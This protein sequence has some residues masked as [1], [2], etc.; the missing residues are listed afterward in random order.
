MFFRLSLAIYLLFLTSCTI[1]P[2]TDSPESVDVSFNLKETVDIAPLIGVSE[3]CFDGQLEQKRLMYSWVPGNRV[4]WIDSTSDVEENNT[5]IYEWLSSGKRFESQMPSEVLRQI[6]LVPEMSV[7]NPILES[8]SA[9]AIIE[10]IDNA[11]DTVFVDIFLFGGTFGTE[12]ARRLA[13]AAKRGVEVVVLHDTETVFAVGS[14]IEPLWEAV[15]EYGRDNDNFVALRSQVNDGP[16]AIPFGMQSVLVP[17]FDPDGTR[18]V[19]FA[20]RSDHSKLLIVD[21]FSEHPSMLVGSKNLVDAAASYFHDEAVLVEGP[22]AALAQLLFT[23]DLQLALELALDESSI[24]ENDELLLDAW[25][26]ESVERNAAKQ[27]S[28]PVA[29]DISVRLFEA[30]ADDS[31]RN[32]E[33]TLLTEIANAR[34]SISMYGRLAYNVTLARAIAQAM[35][36]G[37]DVRII[38]DR[39]NS[40]TQVMNAILPRLVARHLGDREQNMPVRWHRPLPVVEFSDEERPPLVQEIHAKTIIVDG[41]YAVFGSTNFDGPSWSGGF[42]EIGVVVKSKEIAAGAQGVFDLLWNSDEYTE[43]HNTV[44]RQMP[45]GS[46]FARDMGSRVLN[47]E[48]VR[49][50]AIDPQKLSSDCR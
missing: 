29:G 31:V 25:I 18:D 14:E 35:K 34:S 45:W 46:N 6:E 40:P 13:L 10:M 50:S 49:T 17:L 11:E 38:L 42:R 28:I 33:H 19:S 44:Y 23:V 22:A 47:W 27:L 37:V 21:G 1:P 3:S 39:S 4:T 16:S 48:A 12:I 9:R 26:R 2:V 43:S 20:G 30:N 24:D 36:R 41:E 15:V 8:S 5:Y 32:L 7:D